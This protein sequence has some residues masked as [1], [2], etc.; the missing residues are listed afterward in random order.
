MNKTELRFLAMSKGFQCRL[1]AGIFRFLPIT[2]SGMSFIASAKNIDWL[3]SL[4]DVIPSPENANGKIEVGDEVQV[5]SLQTLLNEKDRN[6][7][8]KVG[9]VVDVANIEDKRGRTY[10]MYMVLFPDH[11][12]GVLPLFPPSELHVVSKVDN[13]EGKVVNLEGKTIEERDAI[14][15]Q[16]MKK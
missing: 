13:P 7:W 14:V 6:D 12:E 2:G 1:I 11:E 3:E 8:G 4:P 5:F 10:K 9:Q 16:M 15:A